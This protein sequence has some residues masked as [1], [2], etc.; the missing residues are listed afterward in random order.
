MTW[1]MRIVLRF[2]LV[3]EI[4]WILGLAIASALMPLSVAQSDAYGIWFEQFV[5]LGWIFGSY[6][7]VLLAPALAPLC[8]AGY[9]YS[10][11][12]QTRLLRAT[13]DLWVRATVG[14]TVALIVWFAFDVIV[15]WRHLYWCHMCGE[16]HFPPARLLNFVFRFLIA[17][18]PIAIMIGALCGLASPKQS[19]DD[20]VKHRGLEVGELS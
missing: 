2:V 16:Q 18:G 3:G 14:A 19:W 20:Y 15:H 6:V 13:R 8:V 1:T 4:T 10:R 12:M 5:A 11:L 17:F 7:V 9:A